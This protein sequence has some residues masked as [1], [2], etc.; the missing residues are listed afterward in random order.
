MA[1]AQA[2]T[3]AA[4]T[5]QAGALARAG[6]QPDRGSNTDRQGQL[7]AQEPEA[8]LARL[9]AGRP[10]PAEV[11]ERVGAQV[12]GDLGEVRVH[13]DGTAAQM[14]AAY[15]ARAFTV[16]SHIVFG[17]GQYRPGTPGGDELIAHEAAHAIQQRGATR[18][19]AMSR[20]HDG[21]ERGADAAAHGGAKAQAG[22]A[23]LSIQRKET[24]EIPM[25]EEAVGKRIVENMGKVNHSGGSADRGVHYAH[26]YQVMFPGKWKDEYRMGKADDAFWTHNGFMDWTIKE[27]V[28]ASKALGRWL[29]GGTIAECLTTIVACQIDAMRASLGN[30]R[31]DELFGKE[32]G[33]RPAGRLL[34]IC[35]NVRA[36]PL[37]HVLD[38]SEANTKGEKGDIGKRPNIKPGEWYYFY[39]HPKYLLKHP[40][41]A[42]Q[43]EN[44]LYDGEVNGE[45]QWSG[46]GAG[47][48][49]EDEMMDQMVRAYG[50]P[51]N[52]WDY[53][54]LVEGFVPESER[55][56]ETNWEQLYRAHKDKIPKEY[57]EDSGEFPDTVTKKDIL[58]APEYTLDGTTRKGGFMLDAG[59]AINMDR[60][61]GLQK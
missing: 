42:W 49:T 4:P 45:Q 5:P 11:A 58:D 1:Q 12:G 3:Q 47:G 50:G 8:V 10:L 41:G 22:S 20:P 21:F 16:G 36:T 18:A 26:N 52:D 14:A 53:R 61:K 34:R 32:G 54:T 2:R 56:G 23:P 44:A 39:N 19:G 60:L 30:E 40:G 38:T 37:G 28:S 55:K 9:G 31:F 24:G 35:T 17:A 27:G 25:T 57:R 6:A 43:G 46:F 29:N 51:R 7:A 13:D 33:K 15:R 59:S 48:V